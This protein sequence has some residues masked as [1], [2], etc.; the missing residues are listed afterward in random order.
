MF[1]H[2]LWTALRSI[3]WEDTISFHA[4]LFRCFLLG[5]LDTNG[6]L[7]FFSQGSVRMLVVLGQ[8]FAGVSPMHDAGHLHEHLFQRPSPLGRHSDATTRCPPKRKYDSEATPLPS[9]AVN[10]PM[11]KTMPVPPFIFSQPI[12]V[13]RGLYD[14]PTSPTVAFDLPGSSRVLGGYDGPTGV[15]GFILLWLLTLAIVVSRCSSTGSTSTRATC[16]SPRVA[17]DSTTSS[18]ERVIRPLPQDHPPTN[19]ATQR[20]VTGIPEDVDHRA[21]MPGAWLHERQNMVETLEESVPYTIPWIL[22]YFYAQMGMKAWAH[23][24]GTSIFTAPD[25]LNRNSTDVVVVRR[26]SEGGCSPVCQGLGLNESDL[27]PG[28]STPAAFNGTEQGAAQDRLL[29]EAG[30]SL[31]GS[32]TAMHDRRCEPLAIGDV[33]T[34][35]PDFAWTTTLHDRLLC[36]EDTPSE[37]DESASGTEDEGLF[38]IGTRRTDISGLEGKDECRVLGRHQDDALSDTGCPPPLRRACSTGY[39]WKK[40]DIFDDDDEGP[41]DDS[42]WTEQVNA[43][44]SGERVSRRATCRYGWPD[45]SSWPR[46]GREDETDNWRTRNPQKTSGAVQSHANSDNTKL[47]RYSSPPL[48]VDTSLSHPAGRYVYM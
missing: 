26:E 29:T 8:K 37:A 16:R 41:S 23:F 39:L 35:V 31:R 9:F 18:G 10:S 43:R 40:R 28:V 25:P 20:I 22:F 32:I 2:P 45:V 17:V 1:L 21:S 15:V 46:E 4:R 38:D 14:E 33:A 47:R 13:T 6:E 27:D 12:N 30:L 5:F 44:L 7:A 34:K 48:N 19:E 11:D 24:P 3:Q 36:Q 42:Y